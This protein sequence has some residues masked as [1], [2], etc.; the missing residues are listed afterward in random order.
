MVLKTD[1]EH[2]S[3]S[4]SFDY[5]CLLKKVKMIVSGLDTKV[6]VKASLHASMLS[7]MF[8]KKCP[9]ETNDAC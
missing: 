2:E 5:G 8:M 3:N 9:K 6:N 4:R 7:H 1:Y